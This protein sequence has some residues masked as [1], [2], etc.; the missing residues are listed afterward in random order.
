M[1]TVHSVVYTMFLSHFHLQCVENGFIIKHILMKTYFRLFLF[2]FVL[3]VVV[4]IRA[5]GGGREGG[6]E[7]A[8]GCLVCSFF[9]RDLLNLICLKYVFSYLFVPCLYYWTLSFIVLCSW[10]SSAMFSR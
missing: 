2:C 10:A 5:W 6:G 3:S 8:V 4:H 7:N 1:L 9:T